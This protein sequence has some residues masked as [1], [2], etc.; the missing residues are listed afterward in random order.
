[1]KNR[2]VVIAALGLLCSGFAQQDPAKAEGD[3]P[4]F[5]K[6][7]LVA[8]NKV[9]EAGS[10]GKF[11]L[12]AELCK[13]A[14]WM[15]EDVSKAPKLSHTDSLKRNPGQRA[16]AYEYNWGFIAENIA[17]GAKDAAEAVSLWMKSPG[18]KR[19]MLAP[20]PNELGVGYFFNPKS[21]SVKYWVILVG[22][23]R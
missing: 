8:C 14:Q 16:D 1:M 6:E 19:N 15:A 10:L 4:D 18:H 11:T 9:R 3:F 12:N 17:G 23:Q 7:M 21:K 2:L 22:R 5:A 13:A 20:E